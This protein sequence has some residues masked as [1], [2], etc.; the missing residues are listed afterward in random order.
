MLKLAA[1]FATNRISVYKTK[2]YIPGRLKDIWDPSRWDHRTIS[3]SAESPSKSND[4]LAL[5]VSLP[6]ETAFF[7]LHG[8]G[9]KVWYID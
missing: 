4:S 3:S 9:K 5:L 1:R 6:T 2:L 7:L 8:G